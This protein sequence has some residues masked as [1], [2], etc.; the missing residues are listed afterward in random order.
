MAYPK[1][2]PKA[3]FPKLEQEI[4][5]F[6]R[7]DDTFHKSLNRTKLGHPFSFYDGPPFANG[8]PHWGHLGVSAIKDM[9]SRYQTMRG[10]HVERALGWDCHGL[11]AENSVEKKTRQISQRYCCERWY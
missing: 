5:A 8:L 7:A 9:V 6:W 1:T 10:K 3:N 2:E 11:P 4:I